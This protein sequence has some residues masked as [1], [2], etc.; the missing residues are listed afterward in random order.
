MC[1]PYFGLDCME[2]FISYVFLSV[3]NLLGV[4]FSLK[5]LL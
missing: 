2:L 4:N 1:V 3:G 5:Y